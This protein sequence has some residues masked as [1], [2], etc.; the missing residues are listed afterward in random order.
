MKL[1]H[2]TKNHFLYIFL[3]WII[4]GC[5]SDDDRAIDDFPLNGE[6]ELRMQVNGELW[7]AD[8]TFIQTNYSIDQD[9]ETED[10]TFLITITAS[11]YMDEEEET[12]ETL[13][14]IISLNRNK[15]KDPRGTY[16]MT[17]DDEV[18]SAAAT[19]YKGES[20]I[21]YTSFNPEDENASAVGEISIEGYEIGEQLFLGEGYVQLQGKFAMDLYNAGNGE[22]DKLEIS[23]GSFH[24]SEDLFGF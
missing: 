11:K 20:L 1:H 18:N 16:P 9:S 24:I 10:D 13:Q 3:L 7:K 6:S 8:Y 15:F 17:I 23:E 4:M 21:I 12:G 14:L 22:I 19:F 2:L 5:S